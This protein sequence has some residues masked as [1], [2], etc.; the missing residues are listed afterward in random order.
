M[1]TDVRFG[2]TWRRVTEFFRLMHS[3]GELRASDLTEVSG[4]PGSAEVLATAT[5]CDSLND[6]LRRVIVRI[7]EGE[8]AQ[9]SD[10]K[11][12]SHAATWSCDGTRLAYLSAADPRR[13][14]HLCVQGP[15]GCREIHLPG[16]AEQCVWAP[17]GASLLVRV[18]DPGADKAGAEGSGHRPGTAGPANWLPA[19]DTAATTSPGRSLWLV[20]AETGA[21]RPVPCGHT[22]WEV[23][24]AGPDRAVAVVSAGATESDWYRAHLSVIDLDTG[25][26]TELYRSERQL[27]RPTGSPGGAWIAAVEADCSDRGIIAGTLLLFDHNGQPRPVDTGQV[28]VT[29]AQWLDDRRLA[30]SGMRGLASVVGVHDLVSGETRELWATEAGLGGLHEP[31]AYVQPDETVLAAVQQYRKPPAIV[32]RL[33]GASTVLVTATHA[34]TEALRA[35]IGDCATL[36]WEAPD[37]ER[38]EGLFVTPNRP[39]PHPLIVYLHGGPIW[40]FRDRWLG[41]NPIIALLASHGYAVLCP[42]PRGSSGRGPEFVAPV[43]GDVGGLDGGD[44]LAG[45][46]HLVDAGPVDPARIGVM[47]GSYGGYMTAWLV[48]QDSRFKAAVPVAPVTHWR[49][50]YYTTNIPRF[51]T[52][53]VRAEPSEAGGVYEARSP[54]TYVANVR[55]PCLNVAGALDLCT[56]ATEA[57]QFHRALLDHGVESALVVYPAEGHGIRTFP[58]TVDY[59]TRV[60]DWFTRFMPADARSGR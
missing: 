17:T 14:H 38:I 36:S 12:D 33:A 49:S 29:A 19:V 23:G 20:E 54:L 32:H 8:L 5:V 47:G 35:Q 7:R 21:T 10:G 50:L 28:Q 39:G 51:V 9:V 46:D 30:F 43:L 25:V 37:G 55:T 60:L 24:Y 15:D 22:V 41:S 1:D 58:A 3:P 44:I 11:A 26:A 56:P 45:V 59:C 16:A 6:P 48:T 4:R 53:V 18:A 40:A 42:N 27:G 34:G 2:A 57:H 31:D 52:N 13:G